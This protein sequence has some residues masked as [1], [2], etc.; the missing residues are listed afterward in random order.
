MRLSTEATYAR[1]FRGVAS[2]AMIPTSR[3]MAVAMP[4]AIAWVPPS[5][6]KPDD[7]APVIV[8]TVP[9]TSAIRSNRR[10]P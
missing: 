8:M 7:R 10:R 2:A 6:H 3:A 5:V 4:R 9:T 1:E